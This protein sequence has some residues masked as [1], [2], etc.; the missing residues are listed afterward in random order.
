MTYKYKAVM[1]PYYLF[2]ITKP[3]TLLL[4]CGDEFEIKITYNWE[5]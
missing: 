1:K 2:C 4:S 5:I 3:L